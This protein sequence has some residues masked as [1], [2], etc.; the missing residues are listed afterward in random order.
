MMSLVNKYLL[1]LIL[2]LLVTISNSIAND[3]Q[4]RV[5]DN[6]YPDKGIASEIYLKKGS[7]GKENLVAYSDPN[8]VVSP[9]FNCD[10]LN[11]SLDCS[12]SDGQHFWCNSRI[13]WVF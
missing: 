11:G 6:Y 1:I 9:N 13:L 10:E 7:K 12:F 8:G 5:V 3:G 4:R 2:T